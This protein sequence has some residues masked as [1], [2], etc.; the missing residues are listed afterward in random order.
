MSD[1]KMGSAVHLVFETWL[2][3]IPCVWGRHCCSVAQS[4]HF[5]HIST[6]LICNA[7]NISCP[8]LRVVIQ[9]LDTSEIKGYL[10]CRSG[11]WWYFCRHAH[12]LWESFN[13]P[14]L[15]YL[16][17]FI[18]RDVGRERRLVKA[19]PSHIISLVQWL[20]LE[21]IQSNMNSYCLC[22]NKD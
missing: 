7:G 21:Q 20:K 18:S 6:G 12:L 17:P 8:C 13:P 5:P 16:M 11:N 3:I 19:S 15:T 2:D 9:T 14:I 22:F 1:S 10:S 4:V